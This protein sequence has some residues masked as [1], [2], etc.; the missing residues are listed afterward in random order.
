MWG[1]ICRRLQGHPRL[2]FDAVHFDKMQKVVGRQANPFIVLGVIPHA[3]G[4]YLA[5]LGSD[6]ESFYNAKRSSAT[7]RR[8][9]TKRK[10]LGEFARSGL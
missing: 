3:N 2:R 6:W 8:D 9:R 1:E 4:A 10:K 7:R 5:S